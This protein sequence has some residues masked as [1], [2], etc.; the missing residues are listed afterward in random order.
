LKVAVSLRL[1]W[2]IPRNLKKEA[3]DSIPAKYVLMCR[4]CQSIRAGAV[5]NIIP[6]SNFSG[7]KRDGPVSA[8]FGC[9]EV[10][11]NGAKSA[12]TVPEML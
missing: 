4:P 11:Y 5:F 2:R 12:G 9:F 7:E 8:V 1:D 10:R 6:T 3:A